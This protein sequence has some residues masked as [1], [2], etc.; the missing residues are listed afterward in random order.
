MT[1]FFSGIG[2]NLKGFRY[3]LAHRNL[4]KFA[5]LP[6]LLNSLLLILML[7]LYLNY[8][9]EIFAFI[10]SPLDQVDVID[11]QGFLWKIAD[12]SLWFVRNLLMVVFFVLA[13]IAIVVI[14]YFLG[15]MVNAPFYEMMV[16]KILIVEGRRTEVPFT[17]KRFG[18]ELLHSLKIEIFKLTLF[19]GGSALLFVLSF[20]PV[21]GFAF[22]LA[23][24]FFASWTFAFGLSS[25][26]FVLEH[27][28]FGKMFKWASSRK[29]LLI[30][31]GLP[32]L[33][34][35]VGILLMNFQVVGGTLLYLQESQGELNSGR[36]VEV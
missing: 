3:F 28:S 25:I 1:N 19:V 21:V 27:A 14:V 30:G 34:P 22:S 29:F 2:F 15:S 23:G 26:A 36:T 16:E 31:F 20:I 32:A 12:V 18:L 6:L 35:F 8:F 24:F 33:I 13:M 10:T 11:P 7:S 17:F 4:W 9:N 5:F